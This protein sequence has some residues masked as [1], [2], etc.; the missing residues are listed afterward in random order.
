MPECVRPSFRRARRL[1]AL[2]APFA[3]AALPCPAAA[4]QPAAPPPAVQQPP[5]SAV[6]LYQRLAT[7]TRVR[8]ALNTFRGMR[9][10]GTIDSVLPRAFVVD[11]A[12]H[13]QFLIFSPGPPLLDRFRI[14]RV[15]FD[16]IETLEVSAGNNR[17][18]GALR[19]GLLAGAIGAGV[20][21]LSNSPERNPNSRDMLGAATEGAVIGM[22]LGGSF[23]YVQGWELWR[24]LPRPEK[25]GSGPAARSPGG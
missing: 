17:W 7:G 21:A 6:R 4:Q 12:E 14:T 24:R 19:W 5:D 8:I 11:T 25:R 13:K 3:A 20:N 10:Q 15:R 9:V 18:L 22:V 16:E 2:V 1:V 23:G